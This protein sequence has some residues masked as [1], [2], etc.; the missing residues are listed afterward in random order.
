MKELPEHQAGGT[1]ANDAHLR[2]RD[3]GISVA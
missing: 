2:A 3:H 1:G